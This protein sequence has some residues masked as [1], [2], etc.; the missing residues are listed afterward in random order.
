MNNNILA[1]NNI[2]FDQFDQD[3]ILQENQ[4]N[5]ENYELDFIEYINSQS[6]E[7]MV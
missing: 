7:Q 6:N 4:V 5:I 3:S 2:A 1:T